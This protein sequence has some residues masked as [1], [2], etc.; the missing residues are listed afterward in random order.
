VTDPRSLVRPATVRDVDTIASIYAQV[1]RDTSASFEETPPT[2][3]EILRRMAAPP[4]LPWLV[5]EHRSRIAGYAYA[6]RHRQRPAYRWS[7][8]CS[9]YLDPGHRFVGLGRLLYERLITELAELGYVSLFAAIALPNPV[10][11]RLHEALGFEAL[12]V[13]RRVGYKH[14]AWHDV[15]WWQRR[16]ADPPDDP[17]EPHEWR[18]GGPS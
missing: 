3:V 6:S 13:F 11:V 16:L 8:D 4:R 17:S 1:V 15:E 2:R 5:A 7:A 18:P 9:I 10:S 12:G 14:G